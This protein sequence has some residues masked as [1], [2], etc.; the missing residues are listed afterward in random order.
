MKQAN[1]EQEVA[2]RYTQHHTETALCV[3]AKDQ[4]VGRCLS[5]S[6]Y[7]HRVFA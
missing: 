3:L 5:A 1:N 7:G 4:A 2:Q 6:I